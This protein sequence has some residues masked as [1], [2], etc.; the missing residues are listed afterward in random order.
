[1]LNSYLIVFLLLFSFL[2]LFFSINYYYDIIIYF[3]NNLRLY[4]KKKNRLGF[5][6]RWYKKV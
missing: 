5:K 6:I 4:P 3:D 1:M 2:V